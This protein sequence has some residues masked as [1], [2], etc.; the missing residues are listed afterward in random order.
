L[1][2]LHAG[3]AHLPTPHKNFSLSNLLHVPHIKKNLISVHQFTYDN[4]VFLEFHPHF[5]RVKDLHTGKLLLQS[6]SKG[7]LY[8][9]PSFSSPKSASVALLGERVSIH[10]WHNRLGHPAPPLVRRIL[11]KHHLPVMPHKPFVQ[12]CPACQHGKLHKLHFGATPS[13]SSVPLELLFLDVWGP[14]PL[15]SFNNKRYFLCIVDDFSKYIWL[16]PL[17]QKYDVLATFTQFKS[18]VENFFDRS[19]KSIQTDGGGEFLALQKFLSTH[20]ISHRKTC[21]HTHHQNGSVERKHRQIVDTGLALLAHS[22]VPF[23]HWD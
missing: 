21:P 20:G 19:I 1:Q 8:P 14:A 6:P 23:V 22:H 16:F 7:G 17:T 18:M 5:F 15:L 12:L 3:V 10:Q 2:I 4:Q 11:S 9:C 13:V